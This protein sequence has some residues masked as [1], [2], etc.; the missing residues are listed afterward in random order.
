M[1]IFS[2]NWLGMLG[3]LLWKMRLL[4]LGILLSSLLLGCPINYTPVVTGKVLDES[5]GEPIKDVKI[6]SWLHQFKDT[7]S[8]QTTFSKSDG[9]F[10]VPMK[11]FVDILPSGWG[12]L[13]VFHPLYAS[14]DERIWHYDYNLIKFPYFYQRVEIRIKRLSELGPNSLVVAEISKRVSLSNCEDWIRGPNPKL[15]PEMV[16]KELSE[17]AAKNQLPFNLN[18]TQ[19]MINILENSPSFSARSDVVEYFDKN[20]IKE[21]LPQ[22]KECVIKDREAHVRGQCRMAYYKMTGE[23]PSEI[24]TEDARQLEAY[25]NNPKVVKINSKRKDNDPDKKQYL[26]QKEA[27]EKYKAAH[28]K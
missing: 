21:A 18:D 8:L 26:D 19:G 11:F 20:Q 6:L 16:K 27:L 10:F 14:P 28:Q 24:T 3:S 13:G 2:R 23:Y 25:L 5:T 12:D 9:S 7:V 15:D 4:L 22:L 1:Q 17:V